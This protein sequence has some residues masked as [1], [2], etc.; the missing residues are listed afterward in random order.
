[1]GDDLAALAADAYVYG[2]V[3]VADMREVRRFT[4][5][6]MGAIPAAAFNSFGHAAHLQIAPAATM[7]EGAAASSV[8][9]TAVVRDPRP[10]PPAGAGTGAGPHRPRESQQP[11]LRSRV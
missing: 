8:S 3:L 5:E 6:G 11:A 10:R 7:P 1:L 4:S 9:L 2:F